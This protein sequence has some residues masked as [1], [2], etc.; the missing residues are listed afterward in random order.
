MCLGHQAPASPEPGTTV[1]DSVEV[2]F[3][4]VS[5]CGY[6]VL[7][8]F[9][10]PLSVLVSAVQFWCNKYQLHPWGTARF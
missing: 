3:A 1:L 2:C 9:L 6:R 5:I 7:A 4:D 10:F 8:T